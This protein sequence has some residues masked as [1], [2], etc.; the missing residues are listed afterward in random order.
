MLSHFSVYPR[1]ISGSK[2]AHILGSTYRFGFFTM[3]P[4]RNLS[5]SRRL[6]LAYP[7]IPVACCIPVFY[8]VLTQDSGRKKEGTA[9]GSRIVL[10]LRYI[11]FPLPLNIRLIRLSDVEITNLADLETESDIFHSKH[12]S[13]I[14]MVSPTINQ[15]IEPFL[16]CKREHEKKPMTWTGS[17]YQPSCHQMI[18]ARGITGKYKRNSSPSSVYRYFTYQRLILHKI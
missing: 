6:Q 7:T 9:A 4:S 15:C 16:R 2:D 5:K 8:L 10:F 12:A 13:H 17:N 1:K 14:M 11:H 3:W 18:M